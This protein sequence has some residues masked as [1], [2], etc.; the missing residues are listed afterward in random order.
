MSQFGTLELMTAK[1]VYIDGTFYSSPK[2]YFQVLVYGIY[3]KNIGRTMP[4]C[5][6][7][8]RSKNIETYLRAFQIVRDCLELNNKKFRIKD[9]F[10]RIG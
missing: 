8:L 2:G 9:F 3:Q 10:E 4:V 6:Q 7:L 1:H 5:W